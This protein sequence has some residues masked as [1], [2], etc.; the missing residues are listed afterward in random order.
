MNDEF[1]SR[2]LYVSL[3]DAVLRDATDDVELLPNDSS[4]QRRVATTLYVSLI[5]MACDCIVLLE[6]PSSA[7]VGSILKLVLESYADLCAVLLDDQ[8]ADRMQATFYKE[9]QRLIKGAL[10]HPASPFSADLT[11]RLDI[12]AERVSLKNALASHKARGHK[13]LKNLDRFAAL[14]SGEQFGAI[15]WQLCTQNR[16]NVAALQQ[17]QFLTTKSGTVPELFKPIGSKQV[18]QYL[19]TL[20][21]VVIH[22]SREVHRFMKTDVDAKYDGHL[23]DLRQL[24]EAVGERK[25]S[26]GISG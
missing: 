1:E 3:S 17:R 11:A 10:K 14:A 25:S 21:A 16:Q 20:M 18:L 4:R 9:R 5:E 26:E 15:Y 22:A 24:R 23:R 12:S 6:Q 7:S 8:Y 19:D 13:P 2:D